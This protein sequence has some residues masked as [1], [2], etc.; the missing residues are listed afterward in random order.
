MNKAIYICP[1][2]G[3]KGKAP[4]VFLCHCFNPVLTGLIIVNNKTYIFRNDVGNFGEI[5]AWDIHD[6]QTT[7]KWNKL[8]KGGEIHLFDID[9]P[10]AT[11]GYIPAL[12]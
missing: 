2:C 9:N 4:G 7:H 12:E 1:V 5:W 6:S 11:V 10:P 8:P 3:S